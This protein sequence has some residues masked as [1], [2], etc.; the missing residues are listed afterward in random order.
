[1]EITANELKNKIESGDKIIVAFKAG[2]CGPCKAMAPQ[3]EKASKL[4][5]SA[6]FYRYDV[7]SN[8]D[9]TRSLGIT[10]IPTIKVFENGVEILSKTGYMWAEDIKNLVN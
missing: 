10:S 1:M 6:S 7:D 5:N 3:F 8:I 2:W 4:T 9:Y